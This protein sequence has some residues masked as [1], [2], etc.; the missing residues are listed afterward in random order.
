MA[1]FQQKTTTLG[2]HAPISEQTPVDETKVLAPL[3][4]GVHTAFAG[5]GA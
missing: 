1:W 4:D 3:T 2:T 5:M